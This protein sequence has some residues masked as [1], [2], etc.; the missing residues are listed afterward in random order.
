MKNV[1]FSRYSVGV[2][3]IY[4]L[5]LRLKLRREV[6]PLRIGNK[7]IA[8]RHHTLMSRAVCRHKF[9]RKNAQNT[10]T[11]LRVNLI[12]L[13]REDQNSV[14]QNKTY[15]AA[16]L[17][18]YAGANSLPQECSS[19]RG[20]NIASTIASKRAEVELEVRKALQIVGEMK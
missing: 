18:N 12:Q 8:Y 19:G 16:F 7:L 14:I 3:P 11:G 4:R 13:I 17:L 15:D 6:K 5:K 1:C 10:G 9:R 20:D 2:M